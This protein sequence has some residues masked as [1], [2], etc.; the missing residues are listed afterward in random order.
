ME[1]WDMELPPLS[2]DRSSG[3]VWD[4]QAPPREVPTRYQALSSV[5][6]FLCPVREG[7]WNSRHIPNRWFLFAA[8]E[9]GPARL[10]TYFEEPR[11]PLAQGWP[12]TRTP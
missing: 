10:L 6:L 11:A 12:P 4:R 5:F 7:W 2:A 3:S 9:P 1:G 8:T